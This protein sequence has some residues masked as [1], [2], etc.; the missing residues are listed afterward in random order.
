M[1]K[2]LTLAI[3]LSGLA[4][5]G[6][7]EQLFYSVS[8]NKLYTVLE[9]RV[10]D[11]EVDSSGGDTTLEGKVAGKNFQV[12]FYECDDGG[13]TAPAEPESRCLGYEFRA[14]FNDRA[15]DT[16]SINQW[17]ADHHYGKMFKDDDGDLAIQL[18][19][20]VEGGITED[21]IVTTLAWWK[22]VVDSS[23]D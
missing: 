14:Y 5:A 9:D 15:K 7:A 8:P 17:N 19:V 23:R 21:N 6:S 13:L 1:L 3:A 11:L 10:E 20:I 12:Y 18:N 4:S 16:R 2:T 22:A